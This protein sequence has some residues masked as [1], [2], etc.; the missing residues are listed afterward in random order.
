[1]RTQPVPTD[2]RYPVGPFK[3]AVPYTDVQ[4]A[5]MIQDIAD[6]P[7]KLRAAVMGLSDQQLDTPYRDGGW[8]VRQTVHHVADSHLNSYIRFKLAAT[9]NNPTIKTYDEKVWAEF[10]D[11]KQEPVEVS[12]KILDGLHHRWVVL[13]RSFKTEDWNRTMMHPER[14]QLDMTV[15]L[16]LYSWHCKHHVAHIAELRKRKGW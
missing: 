12:L 7:A 11:A 4:R 10:P 1:M 9:E 2:L 3:L 8:T 5:A 15:N 16:A 14:G 6:L 13:L